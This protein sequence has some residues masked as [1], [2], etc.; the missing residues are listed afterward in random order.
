VKQDEKKRI[1]AELAKLAAVLPEVDPEAKT[2]DPWLRA[3]L[4]AQRVEEIWERF[5]EII[6]V[7]ASAF[8]DGSKP[9][10][11]TGRYMGEGPYVGQKGKYEILILPN[12][13]SC[14]GFLKHYFGLPI[15]RTQ[16]WN[17]IPRDTLTVAIHVEQGSLKDEYALYGHVAFNLAI[18]LL[19]GY[20]HY[21]Y[22]MPVW[23]REGLAHF[24][25]REVNPKHNTFD[26]SEGAVAEM[27][28]KENWRAEVKKMVATGEAVRMA[29]LINLKSYAEL[30]LAHHYT[31]WSMTDYLV[32]VHPEAYAQILD[33]MK[34]RTLPN[35]FPDGTNLPDAHREAFKRFLSM[36]YPDFDAAW[37]AWVT[38]TY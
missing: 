13:A 16:R 14:F 31:V 9:W 6:R 10:D 30:K 33:A 23:I 3:H 12:E 8:P 4:Y 18:M 36:G 34:G 2:L 22:D 26:S 38:A 28:N 21:S 35:G 37:K 32:N 1:R 20:K 5:L 27:T 24:L 17:V 25:E 19:D 29:E 7:P 15:K 11:L